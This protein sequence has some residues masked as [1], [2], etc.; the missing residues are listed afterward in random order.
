MKKFLI[1]LALLLP[2]ST[3]AAPILTVHATNLAQAEANF[4]A[5]LDSQTTETFESFTP[6]ARSAT[7]TTA[8]GDFTQVAAGSGGACG[9]TCAD[10]LGILVASNSPFSGRYNTTPQGNRWLDSFDSMETFFAPITGINA[11]GFYVTDPND[12]GGRMSL[13]VDDGSSYVMNNI[14]NTALSNGRAF[15][16]TITSDTDITGITFLKDNRNDGFGI[17]DVTVARVPEP[18]SLALL[19]LG[20]LGVGFTRKLGIA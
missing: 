5:T 9:S 14:F 8:V 7:F 16:L 15:Y 12:A 6:G 1:V 17:D 11:I 3:Q 19:G 2:L 20:L 13:Q 4:L 18:S 10:G